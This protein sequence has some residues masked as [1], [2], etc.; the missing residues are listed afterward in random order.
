MN[1]PCLIEAIET[2]RESWD[3]VLRL[4]TD[5]KR[6]W[7]PTPGTWSVKDIIAHVAWHELEMINLIGSKALAGSPWWMLETDERNSNIYGQYKDTPLAEVLSLASDAYN[8]MLDA[9][10]TLSEEDLNEAFRFKNMPADW[11]PWKLI[12]G[13]TYKHYYEHSTGIRRMVRADKE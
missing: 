8:R 4:V 12:A 1:A 3:H 11:S 5:D 6:D 9:I 2:A 13:N 7:K 10:G